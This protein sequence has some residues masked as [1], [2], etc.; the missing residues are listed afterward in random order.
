MSAVE[1]RSHHD[2]HYRSSSRQRTPSS[3][4]R[5][6]SS[7]H[8]TPSSRHRTPSRHR[9]QSSRRSS[10]H[11]SPLPSDV[12]DLEKDDIEMLSD[13]DNSSS[14]PKITTLIY[15]ARNKID[16]KPQSKHIQD[17]LRVAV[18]E[19]RGDLFFDCTFPNL[20]TKVTMLRQVLR[21]SARMLDLPQEI[22]TRLKQDQ[23]YNDALGA[24]VCR[25][26]LRVNLN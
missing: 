20:A 8:R 5:T 23:D 25:S 11:H 12:S 4:H 21:R 13:I 1:P 6:P 15:S 19:F 26:S 3:R 18:E 24:V 10:S 17:L 7:R 22:R 16:L 9:S 2:I 14:W